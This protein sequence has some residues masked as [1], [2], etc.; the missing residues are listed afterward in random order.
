VKD[1]PELAKP[2]I[3]NDHSRRARQYITSRELYGDFQAAWDLP[4]RRDALLI[5]AAILRDAS[6]APPGELGRISGIAGATEIRRIAPDDLAA[7]AQ[8]LIDSLADHVGPWQQWALDHVPTIYR[9]E[10]IA[11][12]RQIA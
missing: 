3:S 8:F 10:R 11:L 9:S 6:I 1:R 7:H 2:G 12:R 4:T 5:E